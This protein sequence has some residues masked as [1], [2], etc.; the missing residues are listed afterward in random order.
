MRYLLTK[1]EVKIPEGVEVTVKARVV[2]VKGPRGKLEKSFKHV[3]VDI[4]VVTMKGEKMVVI[5]MWFGNYK[6]KPVVR[7]VASAIQNMVDG[8]TKGHRCKMRAAF[9]HFPITL[10]VLNKGKTLEIRNFVGEKHVKK[11]TMLPG[12][13]VKETD[14]KHQ[15]I[16]EGID[17]D[18]VALTCATINQSL[19]VRHKDNRKFLDG[20]YVSEQGSIDK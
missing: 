20:I 14:N 7:S 2:T 15:I 5:E 11:I 3:A 10:T 17:L 9:A 18:G 19:K 16:I 12:C 8:V 6:N 1:E 13:E 4:R